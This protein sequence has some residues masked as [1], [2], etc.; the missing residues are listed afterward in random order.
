MRRGQWTQAAAAWERV[1]AENPLEGRFWSEL[2]RA[3]FNA[4]EYRE[5]VNAYEKVIELGYGF[6]DNAAYSVARSYALLNDSEMALHWLDRAFKMGFRGVEVARRDSAFR[7]VRDD[8]RFRAIVLLPDLSRATRVDGWRADLAALSRE[9]KRVGYAPLLY[10]TMGAFDSAATRLHDAIPRLTDARIIVEMMKLMRT[11]GDGHTN[12]LPTMRPE[13]RATTPMQFYRFAEGL[14][15]TAADPRYR[16]LLGAQ[17]LQFGPHTAD[18]V[19]R[20]LDPLINRDGENPVWVLQRAPYLMRHLEVLHA[21]ALIPSPREVTLSLRLPDGGTR[22][23]TIPADTTLPNIWNVQPHPPGWVGLPQTLPAPV[24]L[25]L[26]N[27]GTRFWFEV[28]SASRLVYCQI[29]SLRNLPNETLAQFG[30]RLFRLVQNNEVE[31]LVLDLRWNNGGNTALALEFLHHVIR[32][33]KINRPGALF[34]IIGRRT[35]SAAQNLATYLE[36]HTNAVF[37]GEP[38]GSSPN[39]VGEEEFFLLPYSG[40]PANVSELFWQS[41]W[42]WDR[43][44]WIAPLLYAP[45][46]FEAYRRNQDPAMDAIAAYRGMRRE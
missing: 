42:P 27:V 12:I 3:R 38:T 33:E 32:S 34:V 10:R 23:V 1:I 24:P 14:Y 28:D 5:A 35:F 29:N 19:I 6:P 40:I 43:R 30:E 9:V 41:A 11:V 26:R 20:A 39:Y 21:L 7:L 36:R 46:T 15:I 37:V 2:G 4:R 25:Y 31:A 45:P 16:E 18:S 13:F 44:R 8:E 17:V 22:A